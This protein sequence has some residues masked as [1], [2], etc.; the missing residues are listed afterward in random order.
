MTLV[1]SFNQ[2]DGILELPFPDG[3][4]YLSRQLDGYCKA[5]YEDW[6]EARARRRPFHLLK[7]KKISG[8]EFKKSMEAVQTAVASGALSWGG[9]ACNQ[10]MEMGPGL[11]MMVHILAKVAG[12]K[13]PEYKDQ[14]C[15]VERIYRI[16]QSGEEWQ[17]MIALALKEVMSA[18]PNFMLPPPEPDFTVEE[19]E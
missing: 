15:S 5:E 11:V 4:L 17:T 8:M 9:D 7:M 16:V 10:S 6:L 12:K 19:D 14:N 3:P 1:G 13:R 18:S 2:L